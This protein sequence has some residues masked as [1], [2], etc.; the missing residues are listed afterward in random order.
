M[1]DDNFVSV[2]ISHH[3]SESKADISRSGT[4]IDI[5]NANLPAAHPP[6]NSLIF[7]T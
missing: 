6:P 3:V 4:G 7:L 1:Q 5:D 2:P